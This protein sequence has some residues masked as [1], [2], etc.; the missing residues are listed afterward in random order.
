LWGEELYFDS[1]KVKANASVDSLLPR[2]AVEAHL[3]K[4]FEDEEAPDAQEGAI[5]SAAPSAAVVDALP[6]ANDQQLQAKNA[7][8]SDW[9]SRNGAQDRSFKGQRTR[10]SD[11][12]A[13][14][15]DPD[16]LPP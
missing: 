4:L 13:S 11:L 8:N 3:K 12:R 9:I 14:K 15:T 5:R 7:K 6:T 1:T 10:T 16:A 2:F